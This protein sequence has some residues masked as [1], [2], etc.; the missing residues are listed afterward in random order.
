MKVKKVI[1]VLLFACMLVNVLVGCGSKQED[2]LKIVMAGPLTGNSAQWG[3]AMK[4]GVQLA[5]DQLNDKGGVLGKKVEVSYEDDKGDPK[6]AVNVAQRIVTNSEYVG[7]IGH[8]FTSCTMAASP[9]YQKAG[10]PEIAVASTN[11]AATAAGDYIFRI[12]PT[13]T[14]QGAGIVEWLV[15][16]KDKKRIAFIYVNDD[17][18]KGIFDIAKNT[19]IDLGAEVVFEGTAAPSGEQDFS[20]LI[21]NIKNSNPD[22]LVILSFYAVGAQILIQANKMGLDVLTVGSDGIYSPDLIKIA[23]DAAEGL[24]VATWFHPDNDAPLTVEY[25]K[26]YEEKYGEPSDT[27]AP[28]AY[29]ATMVLADAIERAGIT[30][31]SEIRDALK[32]TKQ[33]ES[34]VGTITFDEDRVPDVKDLTLLFVQVTDGEFK[35]IK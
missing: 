9:V 21:S 18:G 10:I 19:A 35:L 17:Y 13:N 26:D 12:N 3:E 2:T 14:H 24:Y 22:A 31:R 1:A 29:V 4:N 6:E 33:Y 28:Y 11:P 16:E 15:K 34:P 7:V 30:E 23:G 5:V 20:V 32:E 27:W 8:Y 25:L